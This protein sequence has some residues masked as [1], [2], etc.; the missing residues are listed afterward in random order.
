MFGFGK[1]AIGRFNISLLAR[2]SPG[3]LKKV[4]RSGGL[5]WSELKNK[6]HLR[7]LRLRRWARLKFL[8][9]RFVKNNWALF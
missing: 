3:W 7:V 8:S 4:R 1:L 2:F 6:K 9:K 5:G